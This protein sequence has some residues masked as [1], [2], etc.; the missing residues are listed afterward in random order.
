MPDKEKIFANVTEYSPEELAQ[1]IIDGSF[2]MEELC[3]YNNTYGLVSRDL[4]K[5]IQDISTALLLRL[6]LLIPMMK[7][8]RKLK[9]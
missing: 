4:R 8:G 2:S 5:K 9:E 6:L 3:N 1:Y 7:L